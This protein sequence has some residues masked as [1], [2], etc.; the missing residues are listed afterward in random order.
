MC[1]FCL[2]RGFG[3]F[4]DSLGCWILQTPLVFGVFDVRGERKA[5]ACEKNKER[6]NPKRNLTTKKVTDEK[7]LKRN[8]EEFEKKNLKEIQRKI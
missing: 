7:K 3:E 6:R 5:V 2:G 4:S 1:V 8:P